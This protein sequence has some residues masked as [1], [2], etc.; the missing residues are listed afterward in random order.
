MND[1]LD[2][3]FVN[4]DPRRT[5][6]GNISLLGIIAGLDRGR[7][8]AHMAVPN[9]NKYQDALEQ[10]GVQTV[11][12]QTNNWWYPTPHH[13]RLHLTGLRERVMALASTLRERKINLVYTNT[14]YAFEG[15]L[16]AAI[17]GIPHVWAQRVL[18]AA[19]IDVLKHFP[20]SGV[21]LAHLMA[22]LSDMVVPNSKAGLRSF[23]ASFPPQKLQVIESGLD[24]PYSLP[25]QTEAK[26][27]LA[28]LAGI[29]D[30]SKIV[31]TV[32]RISPEKD[33]VTFIRTAAR[34]LEQPSH[35]DVH[36]IHVGSVTAPLYRDE[37]IKLCRDLGVENRVHFL[38]SVEIDR[39][40]EIYRGADVFLLASVNF[41]GFAR[42][43]AEAMLAELPS[44][45]TR[46]GGP[47]D[48][49]REGETGFLCD[50]G[51]VAALAQRVGWILDNPDASREMGAR[52]RLRISDHYDKRIL[53]AK[54]MALFEELVSRPRAANPTRTL[55]IELLINMLALIGQAG[56]DNHD[57][58]R[59]LAQAEGLTKSIMDNPLTRAAKSMLRRFTYRKAKHN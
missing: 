35:T 3:L 52:A 44:I 2:I 19:D 26:K 18:F 23:P 34:V 14:E 31:L 29:S 49:L 32:G 15:A 59:R 21:G 50:V 1:N 30:T 57:M 11:D 46:C 22:D 38:G 6:G 25:P 45:S 56:V 58:S 7:F 41:E 8:R 5:A 37:L 13:F 53:N 33:L 51:D 28:A 12:Y 42:V 54:W 40:Y 20:L 55:Q 24:I 4:P 9:N 36:F 16:A 47:E 10:L 48:Y 39:I 43:C 27:I 17:A